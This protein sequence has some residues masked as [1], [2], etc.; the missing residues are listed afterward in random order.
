MVNTYLLAVN[1]FALTALILGLT[2]YSKGLRPQQLIPLFLLVISRALIVI[3]VSGAPV[4]TPPMAVWGVASLEIFSTFC[5]CW[6]LVNP[7]S[8]LP[9]FW[10][11]LAWLAAGAVFFL[12]LL[13]LIPDWPVPPQL[14]IISIAI[15]AIPFILGSLGRPGWLHLGGPL[16]LA[17]AW[18]VSL[19]GQPLLDLSGLTWLI[20]LAAYSLLIGALH[21][22]GLQT[23]W[24]RHKFSHTM[25][26]QAIHLSQERQR[27]V[28]VSEII[29][30]V[31]SLDQAVVHI[32][33]NMAHVTHADQ[34][35]ML[36]MDLTTPGQ[37]NLA[38]IYSPE[39]PREMTE[40]YERPFYLESYPALKMAITQRQQVVLHPQT[41]RYDL[42]TIYA[43]WFEDRIGPTLVQPLLMQGQ[44]TGLLILGNPVTQHPFQRSNQNLCRSLS[45]QITSLV[46]AYRRYYDLEI[47]LA[48][49]PLTVL[50]S[51]QHK[52]VRLNKQLPAITSTAMKT[53]VN[54]VAAPVVEP[55]TLPEQERRPQD[56]L[57]TEKEEADK[58]PEAL[59]YL[60]ILE[61][62]R[63]GVVVSNVQGR[64]KLVNRAAER[65]L[66][67]SRAELL[68]KPIGTIYGEIDSGESIETLATA[69]SRRNEPL[70]TF[71]EDGDR[72][73]QGQL[74]PWRNVDREWLGMIAV[75][76]D[77]TRQVKADRA[78]NDFIS[79]LS[80]VLRG[81]LTIIKGYAELIT[82]GAMADYSPEQ[83]QV[84]RII[85]SSAEKVVQVLDNAIQISAENKHSRL[86]KFENVDIAEAL[87]HSLRRITP[88]ADIHGQQLVHEIQ[89]DLPSILVDRAHLYR[90]VE[91]LL[92]NACRFTPPGGQITLQAGLR[93]ERQGNLYHP[94]LQI[95]VIDNGVGIPISEQKRI[96]DP[97]YRL[98]NQ[99]PNEEGGMGMGLTVVKELV[100]LHNGRVWVD[101]NPGAGAVF[102]VMLPVRQ[103]A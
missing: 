81:P 42:K 87:K 84:Q 68:N 35:A 25:A 93:Q 94:F 21:W 8:K 33:R 55:V 10:R 57:P 18:F 96:F 73:I 34:S 99:P 98:D 3:L 61:S 29:G 22:E 69:F 101:S 2:N 9:P 78:R 67:K 37:F 12:V 54:A 56:P 28:E 38:T 102:Q 5:F 89:P 46:E 90:I 100:E 66:A 74:I 47:Q 70:P 103:E 97:F 49:P 40:R 41:H 92:S 63:E 50:D 85:H 75:F 43:L 59:E 14:H 79:A 76:R 77:V 17:V 44:A 83:L 72:A 16:L 7:L 6:V 80:R 71:F 88:L 15:F 24:E 13:P 86:P 91:N 45:G 82:E 65:I 53:V 11:R 36:I 52:P 20:V 30:A 26:Q 62:V 95:A 64:V 39:R 60:T 51:V 31:P 27:L 58:S 32:S 23:Y 19:L 4:S 48:Q 1:L